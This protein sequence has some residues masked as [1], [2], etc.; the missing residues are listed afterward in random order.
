MSKHLLILAALALIPAC[1]NRGAPIDPSDVGLDGPD[2][3]GVLPALPLVVPADLIL[4]EP[5][6][7]GTNRTDRE[8]VA[9]GLVALG[10]NPGAGTGGDAA[11][12]AVL[13]RNGMDP[14]IR[15]LLA[16][17]DAGLRDRATGGGLFG[18]DSRLRFWRVYGGQA[19]D[20]YAEMARFRA[21][22]ITVPT[23]PPG[24]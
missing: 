14:G 19:L 3:F 4:P 9:E 20:A 6:P 2:E 16:A 17:E 22:G 1:G 11:L 12:V 15:A 21:L 5:T 10:G 8:P 18:R 13:M 7:G 24:G 23:A